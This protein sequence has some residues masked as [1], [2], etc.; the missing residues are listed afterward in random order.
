MENVVINKPKTLYDLMGQVAEA[1]E[2]APGNYYQQGWEEPVENLAMYEGPYKEA[3]GTAYCRAGWMVNL[4]EA[5]TARGLHHNTSGKAFS[6]LTKADIPASEAMELFRGS[7][8]TRFGDP[9]SPGYVKEGVD[10]VKR[11]MARHEDKLKAFKLEGVL[12]D[13]GRI[14]IDRLRKAS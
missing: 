6:L 14:S 3:C 9:G 11:F 5:P 12:D 1:I 7:A 10:G 2:L 13:D 8:C 4:L